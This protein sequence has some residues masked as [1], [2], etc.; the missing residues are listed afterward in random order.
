M[1][2]LPGGQF[3]GRNRRVEVKSGTIV[4]TEAHSV[5]RVWDSSSE[6]CHKSQQSPVVCL[7]GWEMICDNMHVN[8]LFSLK[9]FTTFKRRE[10]K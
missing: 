7:G 9:S 8:V 1:A 4:P 10:R 6:S 5:F 2:T 3:K